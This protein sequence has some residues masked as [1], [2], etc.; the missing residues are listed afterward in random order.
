VIEAARLDEMRLD[1]V[2]IAE[3]ALGA[4]NGFDAR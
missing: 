3:P 2:R 4:D 1:I